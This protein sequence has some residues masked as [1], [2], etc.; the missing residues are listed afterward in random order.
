VLTRLAMPAYTVADQPPRPALR[1]ARLR[2]RPPTRRA[3][4]ADSHPAG[5]PRLVVE[6]TTA[7]GRAAQD[8][9]LFEQHADWFGWCGP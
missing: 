2:G 8:V 1:R 5:G 6:A 9:W 7:D 4:A 3:A